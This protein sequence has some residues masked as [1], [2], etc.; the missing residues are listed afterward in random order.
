MICISIDVFAEFFFFS[1][2]FPPCFLCFSAIAF[3]SY[4]SNKKI[5]RLAFCY[6][7]LR[8]ILYL[9][10]LA[11]GVAGLS[12][13]VMIW[14]IEVTQPI[15]LYL[16]VQEV[17]AVPFGISQI[18]F[19]IKLL[20]LVQRLRKSSKI[21]NEDMP[22]ILKDQNNQKDSS[23]ITIHKTRSQ[24]FNPETRESIARE[25]FGTI[26]IDKNR[27]FQFKGSLEI[28]ARIEDDVENH[29]EYTNSPV[30]SPMEIRIQ[31]NNVKEFPKKITR[32]PLKN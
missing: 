26:D 28:M 20:L 10:I 16:F 12:W 6:V 9:L 11:A 14:P 29:L 8:L 4:H 25:I 2:I 7:I 27:Q 32:N 24:L 31:N 22:V 5:G 15:Y 23:F 19:S 30:L 1:Y 13:L 21:S 17:I 3:V 18:Y